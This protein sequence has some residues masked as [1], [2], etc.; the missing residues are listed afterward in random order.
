MQSIRRE[1][2]RRM[3]QSPFGDRVD[4]LQVEQ[5]AH[6][7]GPDG[8]VD[9]QHAAVSRPGVCGC[10]K[11]P[12]GYCAVCGNLSCVDCHGHCFC[13]HKPICPRHA[14]FPNGASDRVTR[15][16]AECASTNRRRGLLRGLGR[17]LLSPF[18][19]FED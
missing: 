15:V 16:C 5:T 12:G 1:E 14:E 2:K 19:Q 4:E 3:T 6:A 13:C 9:S 7:L 11:E 8:S 17:L 18:V 10:L